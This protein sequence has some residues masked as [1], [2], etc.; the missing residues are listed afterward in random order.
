MGILG[1]I[2]GEDVSRVSVAKLHEKFTSLR[3]SRSRF[4]NSTKRPIMRGRKAV[5]TPVSTDWG[6][7]TIKGTRAIAS[8]QKC[9]CKQVSFPL[10]PISLSALRADLYARRMS[11]V[12]SL[13]LG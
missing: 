6:F 3:R 5:H 8:Y 11:L 13:L 10:S 9:P 12:F 1:G 2:T 7:H 4:Y